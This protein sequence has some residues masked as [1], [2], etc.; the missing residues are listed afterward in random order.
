[1]YLRIFQAINHVSSYRVTETLT[2]W[3]LFTV[4]WQ[5]SPTW[6]VTFPTSSCPC[7]E[8][9][10]NYLWDFLKGLDW[11][12]ERSRRGESGCLDQDAN[13]GLSLAKVDYSRGKRMFNQWEVRLNEGGEGEIHLSVCVIFITYLHPIVHFWHV[14]VACQ[15]SL[16]EPI[17]FWQDMPTA[18]PNEPD[19]PPKCTKRVRLGI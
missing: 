10:Q 7:L 6:L 9:H 4:L 18:R 15:A 2:R 12:W 11:R 16:V 14:S 1:M 3:Y 13:L 5:L 19:L 17:V 8:R